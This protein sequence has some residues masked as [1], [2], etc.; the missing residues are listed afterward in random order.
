VAEVEQTGPLSKPCP[1]C[2]VQVPPGYV[3]CPRCH[4]E[5]PQTTPG[6]KRPATDVGGG[7]TV[8]PGMD[9]TLIYIGVGAIAL[10]ALVTFLLTRGGDSGSSRNAAAPV[11]GTDE[12][13]VDDDT[14]TGG[15]GETEAPPDRP[16]QPVQPSRSPSSAPRSAAS[17]CG[18]RSPPTARSS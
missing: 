6:R 2:G 11:S 8:A 16:A 5:L 15:G 17:G 1:A 12:P 3:K 7:T 9:R 13:V 10:I 18:R 4:A 14:T